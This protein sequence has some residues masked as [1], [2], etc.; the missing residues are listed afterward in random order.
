MQVLEQGL[1]GAE[2]FGDGHGGSRLDDR[3]VDADKPALNIEEGLRL[4]PG[5]IRAS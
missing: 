2:R 4:D 1:D 5:L 3:G